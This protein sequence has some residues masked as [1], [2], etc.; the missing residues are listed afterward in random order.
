MIKSNNNE[1]L[2]DKTIDDIKAIQKKINLLLEG[3]RIG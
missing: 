2:D 1:K 3:E